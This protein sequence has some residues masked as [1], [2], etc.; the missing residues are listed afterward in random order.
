MINI[1]PG[2]C[3]SPVF[4]GPVISIHNYEAFKASLGVQVYCTH[5]RGLCW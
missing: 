3:H 5:I 1:P 4:A 2:Q